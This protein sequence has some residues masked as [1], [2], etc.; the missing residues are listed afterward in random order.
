MAAKKKIAGMARAADGTLL[1]VESDPDYNPAEY[2]KL[3][4]KHGDSHKDA[5]FEYCFY[6][7]MGYFQRLVAEAMISSADTDVLKKYI[8]LKRLSEFAEK[9]FFSQLRR[10]NFEKIYSE[11]YKVSLLDEDSKKN[12]LQVIEILGYDPFADDAPEDQ[13]QLYR[14]MT[15]ILSESMRKD[16]AKARAALSIVRG[17]S[18]IDKYQK[19]INEIMKSGVTGVD[20]ETQ[21][22]LD[23]YIKLQKTMQDSINQ[24]AEKNNFTVKGIGTSGKGMLSDVLNQIEERGIDEGVTNFYDIATSKSIEE[25]ANI[26]FKA[27]LSQVNL[28]KTDYADILASQVKIVKEA[29]SKARKAVEAAR[30]AKEKLKKQE[31]I[32][33]LAAD[34]KSKGIRENEIQEFI[35]REYKLYDM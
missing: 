12:R 18:N 4:M 13:P 2:K 7:N 14:D 9:D 33:E 15:G 8:E 6:H 1:P 28:S 25:V 34:Y 27:Q 32:D 11:D 35:Q 29:Q 19:K 23:Q 10:E 3:L 17:Y 16:V 26:S 5:L 31:L 21:K 20:D 22:L 30:L 24:T